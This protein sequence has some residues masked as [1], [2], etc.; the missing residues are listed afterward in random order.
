[1]IVSHV[2][3]NYGTG[4]DIPKADDEIE[5]LRKKCQVCKIYCMVQGALDADWK[6][7]IETIL[8]KVL[9]WMKKTYFSVVQCSIDAETAIKPI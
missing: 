6:K 3:S 1:M 7:D 5:L 8:L 2:L 4:A 9:S